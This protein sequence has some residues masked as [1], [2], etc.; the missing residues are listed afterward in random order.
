MRQTYSPLRFSHV[1]SP[2][3]NPVDEDAH[4]NTAEVLD[5]LST[6][7]HVQVRSSSE[8]ADNVAHAASVED[9]KRVEDGRDRMRRRTG[10]GRV[11]GAE[12]SLTNTP[13]QVI[14][15]IGLGTALARQGAG[16]GLA[17]HWGSLRY[18]QAL[19]ANRGGYL[20]L[21]PEGRD[22][23]RFYKAAQ[24][25]EI[26]T[27]FASLVAERI[28]RSRYPDH[29]VSVIPADIALRAGWALRST[30]KGSLPEPL[31]R[32][33]HFFV[34]AWRPGHPSKVLLVASKGTHGKLSQVHKQL[35]TATAHVE[36]V[37]VGP[38]GTVPF[39]LVD[40]EIPA[41]ESLAVHLLEAPAEAV[42]HPS[43]GGR[44]ADLD[45][46]LEDRNEL[47]E[48]NLARERRGERTVPGFQVRPD[49]FT[50]FSIV[51]ARAEAATLM[52]FTGGGKP[53]AQYLTNE[54]GKRHF[55]HDNQAGTGSVR[56][57]QHHI[58]GI[59]FVGTDHVFRL[60]GNRVEAFSGLAENLYAHL[61]HGRVNDYRAGV[62]AL[63]A[64][65]PVS[66]TAKGWGPVSIRPDGSIMAMRLL[67]T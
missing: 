13:W 21:S 16:R 32:R 42:L 36:S 31:K 6:P 18:S 30:G 8:L 51:L 11:R 40:T 63:R 12:R 65:W 49:S 44:P 3:G 47:A 53:T 62:H 37:H 55:R 17:E 35:A 15:A 59:D 48:V 39:L 45:L 14:H 58:H 41:K 19:A 9:K 34:E 43:S 24:S 28:V 46:V 2:E 1:M 7:S 22:L 60:N 27:G 23:L 50:W 25:G 52:A 10:Y 4:K 26:G 67:R 64:Q 33:P 66:R 20:Q 61:H 38:H 29:S 5:E 56:D 57:A 54:Q